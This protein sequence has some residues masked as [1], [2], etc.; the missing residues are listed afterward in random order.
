MGLQDINGNTPTD[1]A[2][3]QRHEQAVRLLEEHRKG[4]SVNTF[5]DAE[6]DH[7]DFTLGEGADDLFGGFVDLFCRK[8]KV[9]FKTVSKDLGRN[10]FFF[11][12]MSGVYLICYQQNHSYFSTFASLQLS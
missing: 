9:Q 11:N 5:F 4:S 2:I 8:C 6:E 10:F 3:E 12:Q 7:Y 1:Y